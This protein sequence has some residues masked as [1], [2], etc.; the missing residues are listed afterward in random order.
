[1]ARAPSPRQ[2]KSSAAPRRCQRRLSN[3]LGGEMGAWGVGTFENDTAFNYAL[4]VAEGS[5]LARLESAS[6]HVLAS[7]NAYLE[8]PQAEEA[9]AAADIICTVDGALLETRCPHSED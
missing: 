7:G 2:R 8:A 9:L 5:S 4:E 3:S 1:M 6:D